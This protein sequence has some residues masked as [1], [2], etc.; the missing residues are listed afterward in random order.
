MSSLDFRNANLLWA[1][2]LV[3]T[4]HRLG[5]TTAVICPGSRSGP[6]AIAF[7]QHP[8]VEAL[9]ILDE[10]SAA[11][12]ALGLARR[13]GL[14]VALVCTSGTAGANFYPAIIEAHHSQVP[15][16]VMTA[17]RPPEL[18]HCHAGQ[19]IDQ[20]KL[21]GTYP[22][23]QVEI[24]IPS[25]ERPM[26]DYLRQTIIQSWQRSLLPMSGPVHLNLPFREPLAPLPEPAVQQFAQNFP[27]QDFFTAVHPWHWP[28]VQMS[29]ND[30][31]ISYWLN[32][33]RGLIVAGASQPTDPEGYCQAIA[34][35][36]RLLHWPVLA[37]GLSPLRNFADLNPWLVAGYDLLLRS[38]GLA[39]QFL[40]QQVIQIGELPTSKEL[41]TWLQNHPC[42][43]WIV[44]ASLDNFDP[45][46]RPT[47]HLRLSIA[48]LSH[49]LVN[50]PTGKSTQPPPP[51]Y[52]SQWCTAESQL[53]QAIE[54][55]LSQT[56]VLF[57]GKA[58]WLLSQWLPSHTPLFIAS[59]MPV[60]DVEWFW[61]V[62]SSRISP[63]FNR[64]AN[65]IDGILSTALGV[66]HR[67]QPSVLLTGDLALLHD[68][69]GFL[70][71]NHWQGHLTIVLINNNGGGIFGMLPIAEFEPPFEQFFSTPQEIN[72]AQLCATYQVEHELIQSWEQLS[73]RLKHLPSTG[74]RVLE[75]PC[76]RRFDAQWRKK[77]LPDLSS[78]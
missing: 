12:F 29:L 31:P 56:E 34:T 62:G 3:E 50:L 17:D 9:S 76:D 25:P 42:P 35:L 73:Q 46:H 74:I 65:G 70:I 4:L 28:E 19:A 52:L 53:Q 40:P 45:L 1:S 32:C 49:L 13:S 58:A 59:S 36:S 38:P 48:S 5:L 24:A 63:F 43:T 78:G 64:G 2:V 55:T 26:L 44:D 8:L 51:A 14:P 57:E 11:F 30:L 20:L 21:Y 47:T 71:R 23:W 22:N 27:S 72:F 39:N 77:H 54:Q 60:R 10:R 75:L 67:Q 68:T 66:S 33:D 41:R 7:A 69:N 6:L 16:L 18:R 37:D 15:L 61:Q